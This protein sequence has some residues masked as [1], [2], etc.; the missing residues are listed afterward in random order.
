[1][2][3]VGTCLNM[4]TFNNNFLLLDRFYELTGIYDVLVVVV[5]CLDFVGFLY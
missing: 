1:M 3:Y 4:S 2:P 5:C